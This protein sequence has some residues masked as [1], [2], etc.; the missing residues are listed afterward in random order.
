MLIVPH[1]EEEAVPPQE[2][3]ELIEFVDRVEE[4]EMGL[5]VSSRPEVFF[6]VHDSYRKRRLLEDSMLVRMGK[7][8]QL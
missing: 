8:V 2:A 6:E 1:G 5:R 7:Q 3:V 4:H